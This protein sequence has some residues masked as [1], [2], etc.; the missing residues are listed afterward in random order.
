M[1]CGHQLS[2]NVVFV[3]LVLKSNEMNELVQEDKEESKCC[4]LVLNRSKS[5]MNERIIS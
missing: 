2:R 3:I 4:E 5:I 1:F